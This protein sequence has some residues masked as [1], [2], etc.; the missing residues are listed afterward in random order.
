MIERIT[1]PNL[2]VN[3]MKNGAD[4]AASVIHKCYSFT[5][6]LHYLQ[7]VKPGSVSKSQ[8]IC[9]QIS[10][11]AYSIHCTCK[12]EALL[13]LSIMDDQEWLASIVHSYLSSFHLIPC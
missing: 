1:S 6:I 8:D 13:A 9:L 2:G 7:A 11:T 4:T 12:K 5:I 3:R 10:E